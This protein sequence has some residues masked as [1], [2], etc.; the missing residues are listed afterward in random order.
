M[1]LPASYVKS[2]LKAL[3]PKLTPG[4]IEFLRSHLSK[5]E[6][7]LFYRMSAMDQK[8]CLDTAYAAQAAAHSQKINQKMLLKIALLHDIGKVKWSP[9][10]LY[11]IWSVLFDHLLP[12]LAKYLAKKGKKEKTGK[13]SR[14]L[15]IKKEHGTLSA[16]MLKELD[17]GEGPLYIIAHHHDTPKEKDP[18][19]LKILRKADLEN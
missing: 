9:P 14:S 6:Q 17:W 8:H 3:F 13:L 10:L 16:Q 5:Q 1:S 19:E 18:A 12:P 15:Y 11:R 2:F 4:D 7:I